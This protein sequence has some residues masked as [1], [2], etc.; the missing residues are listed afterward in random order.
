MFRKS[1]QQSGGFDLPKV[2]IAD[3]DRMTRKLV[4]SHV[5]ALGHCAIESSSGQVALTILK[6]NPNIDLLI[7]DVE[8]PDMNGLDLVAH[9]RAHDIYDGVEII[10]ISGLA[11]PNQIAELLALGISMFM[12]KPLQIEDLRRNVEHCARKNRSA[13]NS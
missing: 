11:T 3:D 10:V 13:Q 7:T 1:Y 9:L 4:S 2:L 6:D 5:E 12:A 8:M